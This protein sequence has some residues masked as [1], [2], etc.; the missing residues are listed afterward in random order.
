MASE[1]RLLPLT[2]VLMVIWIL[3]TVPG[4]LAAIFYPPFVDALVYP[5]PLQPVPWLNAGL[6]AALSIGT[7]VASVLALRENRWSS[8]RLLIVTYVVNAVFAEYVAFVRI[9][10]GP[11]PFQLWFYAI[12]GLFYI[13]SAFFIWRRQG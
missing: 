1:Q 11:V 8:T 6:Y 4:G 13:V 2:K 12:L 9:A 10:Q 5:P 3:I 7:G